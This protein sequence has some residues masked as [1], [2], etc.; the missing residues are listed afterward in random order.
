MNTPAHSTSQ[1][2]KG[3]SPRLA[4]AEG[5]KSKANTARI[6]PNTVRNASP[7]LNGHPLL[8]APCVC[9]QS[10]GRLCLARLRWRRHFSAVQA[11]HEAAGGQ[12]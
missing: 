3:E 2:H 1:T 10:A 6:V 5:F 12:A 4:G 11:R 8:F 7:S 9:A